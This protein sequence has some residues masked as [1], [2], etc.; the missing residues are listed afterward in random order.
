[1]VFSPAVRPSCVADPWES[2]RVVVADL[3]SDR[4]RA[5][6]MAVAM[7]MREFAATS[8]CE[9]GSKAGLL[10]KETHHEV[11]QMIACSLSESI[12]EPHYLTRISPP[13][14][15]SYPLRRPLL[16][17]L[18]TESDDFVAEIREVSTIIPLRGRGADV[19]LAL[20][21]PARCFARLV[22]E[23]H[24]IPP[25]V[26]R[27]ENLRTRCDPES[28]GGLAAVRAREPD[29]RGA[30]G[31]ADFTATRRACGSVG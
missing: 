6:L 21:D 13:S 8:F 23:N 14:D 10:C 7:I 16:V 11:Y 1:M 26:R 5:D 19:R 30:V 17:T 27:P 29:Q 9:H 4:S 2:R 28:P 24:F 20:D 12:A 25:H 3:A 22:R 31:Q 18:N 15:S